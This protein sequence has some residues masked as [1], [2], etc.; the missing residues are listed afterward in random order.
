MTVISC[1]DFTTRKPYRDELVKPSFLNVLA[2]CKYLPILKN[3]N[4][5]KVGA[6]HGHITSRPLTF[7][8][9]FVDLCCVAK[10]Q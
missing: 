9:S 4:R 6:R 3:K 1:T 7:S 5:L 8:V 2:K 10:T